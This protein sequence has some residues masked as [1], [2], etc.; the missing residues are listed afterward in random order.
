MNLEPGVE[1]YAYDIDTR[2]VALVNTFFRYLSGSYRAECG[3]ILVSVPAFAADV[4][5]LFKTLPCLEQQEKGIS[6]R[7]ISSLNTRYIAISFPAR[8]MS[9]KSKG[10]GNFY[11]AF[12]QELFRRLNLEYVQFEYP[13]EVFYVIQK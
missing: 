7:I 1:Y 6:E 9:G 2:L 5:F 3:D 4:V 13:N 10:M 12:A 8:T 11:H